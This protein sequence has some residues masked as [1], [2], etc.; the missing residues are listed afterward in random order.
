MTDDLKY[1]PGFRELNV[2]VGAGIFGKMYEP[3]L[4]KVTAHD[5]QPASKS[6]YE[7]IKRFHWQKQNEKS[8][9]FKLPFPSKDAL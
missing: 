9:G 4:I 2:T 1:K 6:L 3:K 8:T 7:I 5:S